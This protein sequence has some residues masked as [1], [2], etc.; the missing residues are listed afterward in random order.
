MQRVTL[1]RYTT[2]PDRA[3]EN[4]KLSR[5]VFTELH[6]KRPAGIAY[7]LFKEADRVSFVHVFINLAHDNSDPVTE[8]SSFKAFQAGILDRC[9]APPKADPAERRPD[10]QLRAKISLDPPAAGPWPAAAFLNSHFDRGQCRGVQCGKFCLD[11]PPGTLLK[12]GAG[13]GRQRDFK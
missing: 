10:R 7:G 3:A 1:V 6:E 9:E 5:A 11:K 2:K 8:L 13:A 12:K 4:E